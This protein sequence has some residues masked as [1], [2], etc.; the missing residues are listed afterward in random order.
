MKVEFWPI[1]RPFLS[2][3]VLGNTHK[4]KYLPHLQHSICLSL[5]HNTWL[6][7]CT[8]SSFLINF[9]NY[10]V[11]EILCTNFVT[12][13]YNG[14]NKNFWRRQ[15]E[16]NSISHVFNSYNPFM[17]EELRKH[18]STWTGGFGVYKERGVPGLVGL[19]IM[20]TLQAAKT[21]LLQVQHHTSPSV[22]LAYD[23]VSCFFYLWRSGSII[24]RILKMSNNVTK[25]IRLTCTCGPRECA[26]RWT[27]CNFGK[28]MGK[29]FKTKMQWVS[30]MLLLRSFTLFTATLIYWL[31]VLEKG[32]LH[33][34]CVAQLKCRPSLAN[35]MMLFYIMCKFS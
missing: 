7:R 16:R 4:S 27:V 3:V 24:R 6:D 11:L 22:C 28:L 20:S 15:E 34:T 35:P 18:C 5:Q 19:C 12:F 1:N 33:D 8:R 29:Y 13:F 10:V 23:L 26:K 32:E 31:Q 17:H 30:Q 14:G 9:Q 25:W 2:I 21:S